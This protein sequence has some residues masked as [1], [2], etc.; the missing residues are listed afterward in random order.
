MGASIIAAM[1]LMLTAG[2]TDATPPL[3]MVSLVVTASL[4]ALWGYLKT[5]AGTPR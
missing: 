4:Y 3:V 2:H 5:T 1:A